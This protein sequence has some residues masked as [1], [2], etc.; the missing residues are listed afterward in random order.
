MAEPSSL[1]D[2]LARGDLAALEDEWMLEVDDAPE[3]LERFLGVARQLVENDDDAR[4]RS[5]LELLYEQLRERSLWAVRLRLLREAGTLFLSPAEVH[6]QVMGTLERLYPGNPSLRPLAEHVGLNRAVEDLRKTWEKVDRLQGILVYDVGAIVWMAGK[7][8]G[9]VVEVN[10]ALETLKI[11]FERQDGLAVGFRATGKL[12]KPLPPGHLLRRKLEEPEALA[13]LRDSDP[14]ALLRAVLESSDQPLTA[15]EIREHL[16]G[17]VSE[18]QWTSWWSAARRHPQVQAT[19][20]GRQAYRWHATSEGAIEAIARSFAQAGS[21]QKMELF[22]KSAD[23]SSELGARMATELATLAGRAAAEDPGYAF[24]VWF[25]L[26]RAGLLPPHL[27][28]SAESLVAGNGDPRRLLTGIEDRLLRERAYGMLRERRADWT[29]LYREAMLREEDPRVLGLLADGLRTS[30][31]AERERACEEILGQPRR[32]PAAFAWLAEQAADDAELRERNPLR[33]LQQI[34]AALA[35]DE[36]AA[37]RNRLMALADSGGTL[38]RLLSHLS[39]E[40]APVAR[41]AIQRATGL[42]DYRRTPLLNA[43]LMRFPTL[44]VEETGAVLYGTSAAIAARRA[45]LDHLSKVEIPANRKAIEEARAL[46]DLREN[47]EYKSARQRHEYLSARVAALHRDLGRARPIDQGTIDASEVRIGTRVELESEAGKLWALTILGP[48]DSKPEDG[49]V[50]Y[51]SELAK[52]L[53]GR[54][55][56]EWIEASGARWRVLQ[57]APFR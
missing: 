1:P 18:A 24:E 50:S 12:L 26:E 16:A 47:F 33:L 54:R 29:V 30:A 27:T 37:V 45:E 14:P 35:S 25:A 20:S 51:E 41:E 15:G 40:Q 9:R 2:L 31:P 28:W 55:P 34:L 7:G 48:W 6:E 17:I 32:A 56:G 44:K 36:L 46:G 43:L 8:V 53:L 19:S 10:V 13:A 57:V 3:D 5:L 39:E 52:Q 21:R 38:P 4:A 11:D 22:R 49:I 23:R 42:E